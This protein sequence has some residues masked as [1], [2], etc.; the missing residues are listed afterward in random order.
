MRFHITLCL[1][2]I[3]LC[4]LYL[5][6]RSCGIIK[7][8]LC[9]ILCAVE[10]VNVGFFILAGISRSC[11]IKGTFQRILI[12]GCRLI[13]ALRFL[14]LAAVTFAASVT[15]CHIGNVVINR[16]ACHIC[17]TSECVLD[18]ERIQHCAE[19]FD[20]DCIAEIF[21]EAVTG[22]CAV[23]DTDYLACI[24]D[25]RAAGAAGCHIVRICNEADSIDLLN[26]IDDT[27]G[28]GDIIAGIGV[29]IADDIDQSGE[30]QRI[31]GCRSLNR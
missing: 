28:N 22:Q 23:K 11:R 21:V 9:S 17:F 20:I 8:F 13:T 29:D 25:H 30:S 2:Q 18:S 5:F 24:V 14:N 15:A 16:S 31:A 4:T 12:N 10:T 7:D 27:A 26:L 6:L 3:I 19:F 1:D